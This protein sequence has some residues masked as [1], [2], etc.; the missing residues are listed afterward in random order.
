MPSIL[1]YYVV[2]RAEYA[3]LP[4]LQAFRNWLIEEAAAVQS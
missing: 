4:K 1:A 3:S 2:Y